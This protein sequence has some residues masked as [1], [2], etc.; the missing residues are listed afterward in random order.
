MSLTIGAGGRGRNI[1]LSIV[2][3]IREKLTE[4]NPSWLDLDAD[5]SMK[6]LCFDQE[7][8]TPQNNKGSNIEYKFK[9]WAI[10]SIVQGKNARGGRYVLEVVLNSLVND[11]KSKNRL[12]LMRDDLVE[13]FN[14]IQSCPVYDFGNDI[15]PNEIA[16]TD[17]SCGLC[18]IQGVLD[19]PDRSSSKRDDTE[20]NVSSWTL[21]Y[22]IETDNFGDYIA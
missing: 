9:Q 18:W 16:E 5:P 17:L 15:N 2:K 10:F 4:N 11:D 20:G 8:W 13:V 21:K 6:C 1:W 12:G 7:K 22:E 19:S 3:A 14:S